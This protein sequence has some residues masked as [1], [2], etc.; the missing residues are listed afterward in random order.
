MRRQCVTFLWR[1]ADRRHHRDTLSKLDGIKLS[2]V[3]VLVD[4]SRNARTDNGGH[5][6]KVSARSKRRNPIYHGIICVF[7]HC[8]NTAPA[9][10]SS[11]QKIFIIFQQIC[12]NP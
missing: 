10:G 12:T 5:Q 6:D 11:Y 9:L 8:R 7:D 4:R 2:G 1:A 3:C